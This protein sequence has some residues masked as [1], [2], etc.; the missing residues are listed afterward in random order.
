MSTKSLVGDA[1]SS[2]QLALANSP[3]FALREITVSAD[4]ETLLL[5]GRVPTFYY[6]QLAQEAIRAVVE[7]VQV[8]NT[9]RVDD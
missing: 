5:S 2:A 8:V 7:D 3:I 6:K 4:G 9:I 1:E